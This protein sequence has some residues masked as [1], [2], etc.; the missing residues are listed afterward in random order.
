MQNR[1]NVKLNES[2]NIQQNVK[3]LNIFSIPHLSVSGSSPPP[4]HVRQSVSP[5]LTVKS[6]PMSP[7]HPGAGGHVGGD[8]HSLVRNHGNHL[9]PASMNAGKSLIN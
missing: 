5:N 1:S 8:V 6:E 7:R 4:P 3:N 2:L 9:S